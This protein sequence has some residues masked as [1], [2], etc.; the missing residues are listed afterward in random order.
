VGKVSSVLFLD[1][2]EAFP[3]ANPERLV[4]NLRKRRVPKTY[5]SFIYNMLRDQVTSLKFNGYILD[6]ITIDNGIGQGDPLSMV[7]YQYYNVDLLDIPSS[8]DEKA[9][10]YVNDAFMMAIGT[11]FQRAHC[12]LVDMMCKEG[13]VEDWSKTHSFPLK[14]TKLALMNFAHSCKKL[15]S[16]TLHLPY[17]LI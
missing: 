1:S 7:L 4:H 10:A 16:P 8:K 13:G 9:V 15:N 12:I 17:R 6:P 2:E 14:Y 11:D 5:A 3:N